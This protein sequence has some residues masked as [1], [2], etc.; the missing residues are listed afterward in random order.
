MNEDAQKR[1]PCPECRR[2][3]LGWREKPAHGSREMYWVGCRDCGHFAGGN[4]ATI[5]LV[6]WNRMAARLKF[7]YTNK[8]G[9]LFA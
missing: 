4:T 3:A 8:I 9:D 2:V 5:A 7:D 6:N 1:E